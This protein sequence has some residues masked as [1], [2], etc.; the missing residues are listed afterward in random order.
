MERS[1]AARNFLSLAA[2][3]SGPRCWRWFPCTQDS[4]SLYS[5]MTMAW[6]A[7]RLAVLLAAVVALCVHSA[8]FVVAAAEDVAVCA[9][10]VKMSPAALA[11]VHPFAEYFGSEARSH[12]RGLIVLFVVCAG[13]CPMTTWTFRRCT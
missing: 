7:N 5:A 2:S 8:T 13:T 11:Y 6:P 12:A 1:T 4:V 9:G 3:L 10:F